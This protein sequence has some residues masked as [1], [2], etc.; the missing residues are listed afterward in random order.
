MQNAVADNRLHD[1]I[2]ACGTNAVYLVG[3]GMIVGTLF[4]ILV[5]L[6]LDF[7][8]RSRSETPE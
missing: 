2:A 7:V 1:V 4:T 6:L 8:R 3:M 5:L